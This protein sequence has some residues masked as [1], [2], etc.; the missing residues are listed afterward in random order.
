MLGELDM[1]TKETDWYHAGR[2]LCLRNEPKIM[3]KA[4]DRAM[5][6]AKARNNNFRLLIV[7]TILLAIMIIC[8]GYNW[9]L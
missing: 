1:L 2:C 7:V 4:W 5:R 9:P 3:F 8:V 6:W